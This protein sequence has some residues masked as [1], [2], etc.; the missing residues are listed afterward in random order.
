MPPVYSDAVEDYLKVIY[1]LTKQLGKATTNQ[2]AEQLNVTPASVTGMIQ[3][4]AATEPPLVLYQKHRG[5]ELTPEGERVALEV[6]R[7]HRLLELFLHETLGYSWDEVHAEADRLEHVISED[8]EERIAK[9]LG[10][11]VHD[12]HGE[13]IPSKELNLPPSSNMLLRDL[14]P[15]QNATV[16]RVDAAD[17]NLLRYLGEVGLTPDAKLEAFDYSPY[18]ELLSI[19]ITGRTTPLVLGPKITSQVWIVLD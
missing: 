5:V 4:L 9:A 7:H 2:L 19:R 3:K 14:K 18:D 6:I 12:P 1:S 11:P 17:P 13:P 15:G 16:E 8:F 10:N